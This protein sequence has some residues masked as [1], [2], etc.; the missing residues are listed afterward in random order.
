[1]KER[2][3]LQGDRGGAQ[4]QRDDAF[5]SVIHTRKRGKEVT[6]KE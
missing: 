5:E 1:M 3:K 6:G 4:E 2:K